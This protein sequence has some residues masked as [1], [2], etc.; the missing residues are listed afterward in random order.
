MAEALSAA[1]ISTALTASG[2]L[3]PNKSAGTA[4]TARQTIKFRDI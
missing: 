3:A 2:K 1:R 4:I